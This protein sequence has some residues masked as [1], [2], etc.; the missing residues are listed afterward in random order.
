MS[1]FDLDKQILE[2]NLFGVDLN[3]ESVEITKLSLW[4][5]TA[6]RY[7]PLTSLD[8]N[9]KCG[10]SLIDDVS[11]AGDKA[12]VWELE[13]KAVM[14][15]GGFD[16]VI[17]NPPYLRLQ[18][19][20]DAHYQQS[21]FYENNYQAATGNYDIYVLFLEKA[22]KL[23]ANNGISSFILPHKWLI[24]EFGIGIRKLFSTNKA[25][26]KIDHF[27]SYFVFDEVTTYTCITTLSKKAKDA[28]QF[29]RVNPKELSEKVSNYTAISYELLSSENWNLGEQAVANLLQKINKQA[30][31]VSD[32]FEKVFAGIQTSAD[33][34]YLIKGEKEGNFIK[35]YSEQ[36]KKTVILESDFMKPLVKGDDVSRY[37]SLNNRYYVIFPYLLNNGKVKPMIENDIKVNFPKSY[38]YLKENE[39]FLRNREKGKFDNDNWFLFGRQQGLVEVNK[40]KF[41]SPDITLGMNLSCAD[42]TVCIKNGAYGIIISDDFKDCE[43]HFLAIT[44]SSLMWFFLKK[45]GAILRGGYFRFN[46]NYIYN[47]RFPEK[48][49]V[50][51]SDLS[52]KANTML[53]Q[54]KTLQQLQTAFLSFVQA[55][56]KPQK[57]STKLQ[58]YYDLSWDEFKTELKKSKVDL[59]KTHSLN[60]VREWQELFEKEK[61]QALAIKTLI[62]QT[63]KEIDH[64]VYA[65][66]GLTADDIAI[67]ENS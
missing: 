57:L 20:K 11:V 9:I 24:S 66:Y 41:V 39:I 62:E 13:F 25:V 52:T 58:R 33:S 42:E 32:V 21:L 40:T 7:N 54:N 59:N 1:S 27:E 18:G 23:L 65:L 37:K 51:Q 55:D 46:T 6:N 15:K 63:D 67:I 12:F 26:E 28:F 45:T 44:N 38:Q 60:K 53:E 36:L 34:I 49:S 5:K 29:R 31:K 61:Q 2:N 64:L 3:Q 48:S 17:G 14:D 56:L 19:L 50:L 47:F 16:V 35:G 8:N 30:L 10:N 4:L 43:K 22:Y